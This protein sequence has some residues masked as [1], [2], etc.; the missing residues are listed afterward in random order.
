MPEISAYAK[1]IS[2]LLRQNNLDRAREVL[3]DLELHF[4][5]LNEAL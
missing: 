1:D 5:N 2:E 4:E 3:L